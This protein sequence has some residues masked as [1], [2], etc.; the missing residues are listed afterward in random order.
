[1]DEGLDRLRDAQRV[2]T[3]LREHK[4]WIDRATLRTETW[5]NDVDGAINT[6]LAMNPRFGVETTERENLL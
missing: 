6:A 5:V 3:Y 2:I 1:M 4:R